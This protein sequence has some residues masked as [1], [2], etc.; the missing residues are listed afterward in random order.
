MAQLLDFIL[1]PLPTKQDLITFY[2]DPGY[3]LHLFFSNLERISFATQRTL[4]LF[5]QH[6]CGFNRVWEF[7]EAITSYGVG[8][9]CAGLHLRGVFLLITLRAF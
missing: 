2:V 7:L 1:V 8:L 5:L 3:H 6:C 9:T 4:Q